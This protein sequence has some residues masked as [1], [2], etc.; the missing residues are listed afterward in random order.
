MLST[1]EPQ[2][3]DQYW[4]IYETIFISCDDKIVIF[5][6]KFYEKYT[7]LTTPCYDDDWN[8]KKHVTESC[9][10]NSRDTASVGTMI[11]PNW[12]VILLCP[13]GVII[14]ISAYYSIHWLFFR[15]SCIF[16]TI[17]KINYFL[18]VKL[19]M[20]LH[21]QDFLKLFLWVNKS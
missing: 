10:P 11:A 21:F 7:M 9:N 2:H 16:M 4:S 15:W 14:N 6:I 8:D 18:A 1:S 17:Y 19:K 3:F 12:K 20:L 13:V 5:N